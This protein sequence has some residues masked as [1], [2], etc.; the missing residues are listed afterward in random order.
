MLAQLVCVEQFAVLL[1]HH[2]ILSKEDGDT[3]VMWLDLQTSKG[4]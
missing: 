4:A 2:Y 1:S 3:P